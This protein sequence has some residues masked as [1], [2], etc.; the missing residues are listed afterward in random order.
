[1]N[2]TLCLL[3]LAAC[4]LHAQ[5]APP[6]DRGASRPLPPLFR[7]LD[8]NQDGVIDAGEIANA[9][10]ALKKLDLNGDGRL[11]PDEYRPPRPGGGG[12]P[13]TGSGGPGDGPSLRPAVLRTGGGSEDAGPDQGQK[14]PRPPIDTVLDENG[15]E[16][17]DAA[18]IAKAPLLLKKL[19]LNGDGKLSLDECLP[20]RP[21]APAGKAASRP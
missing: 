1:M 13:R 12:P 2:R 8:A 10:A 7:V 6:Q 15:D 14:P 9:A 11:T 19:D 18:E 3:P 21:A 17:I 5:G 20:K 16:V 4:L